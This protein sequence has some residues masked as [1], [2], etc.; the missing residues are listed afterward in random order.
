MMNLFRRLRV[1]WSDSGYI[2]EAE[3]FIDTFLDVYTA[4][5]GPSPMDKRRDGETMREYRAR[6]VE[7]L[8]A[9]RIY[10]NWASD[11]I[12]SRPASLPSR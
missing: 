2:G 5:G 4:S 9:P 7:W 8:T 6:F 1:W 12:A 10:P 11:T 3:E